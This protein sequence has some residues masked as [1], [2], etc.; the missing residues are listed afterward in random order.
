[1]VFVHYCWECKLVQSLGKTIWTFL[2]NIKNKTTI[3]SNSS[4]P[5]H[6]LKGNENRIFKRCIYK[7][8]YCCFTHNSQDMETKCPSVNEWIKMW[9]TH[10]HTI[11][12]VIIKKDILP[13]ATTWLY[14]ED[15]MLSEI[16]QT[17]RDRLWYYL[18]VD[19]KRPNS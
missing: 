13:F 3:W 2:K 16:S 8:D 7:Y 12:L 1:M 11:Y 17:Q 18:Y 6:I 10:T 9:D 19:L 4:T 5:R 14:L 15:S